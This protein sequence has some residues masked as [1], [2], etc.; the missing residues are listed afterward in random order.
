MNTFFKPTK[1]ELD[2]II[3]LRNIIEFDFCCFRMTKTMAE[4]SIIDASIPIKNI[5]KENNIIDFEHIDQGEKQHKECLI[6]SGR[7]FLNTKS[8]FYRP[9]TKSGDPRF[10]PSGLNN[11][12]EVNDLILFTSI[13]NECVLIVIKVDA[14]EQLKKIIQTNFKPDSLT[15]LHK[16]EADL[17][18]IK[19]DGWIDSISP[20]IKNDKD[21]GITLE[22]ALEISPNSFSR[23]DYLDEIEIK[24]K[25]KT[26]TKDSLFAKTPDWKL[27]TRKDN[28]N[29]SANI[30]GAA[31]YLLEFGIPSS[32]HPDFKTLYVTVGSVPN[33]QGMFLETS[34]HQ[35]QLYQHFSEGGT[36]HASC[37]WEYSI[38][39]KSLFKKHNRTVWIKAD[40][41]IEN[42]KIQFKYL[43]FEYS[44]RP[45]FNQFISL[46]PLNIITLDWTHR[47]FPDGTAY[48]DHGFLFRISPRYRNLLFN[49]VIPIVTV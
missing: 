6:F 46:V 28:S 41:R 19:S 23:P 21:V 27:S 24:S 18:R 7:D 17:R 10:W 5:L 26:K 38:L 3:E 45:S 35:Q 33:R 16:L 4:K 31:Y 14:A 42:G 29:V 37:I 1:E 30:K 44:E 34:D 43:S 20:L 25:G 22:N 47:I 40:E 36:V 13:E 32:R 2:L 11:L 9:N 49:K 15:T 39:N 8:S 12:S 48:N